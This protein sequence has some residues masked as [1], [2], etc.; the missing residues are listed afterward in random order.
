MIQKTVQHED[1]TVLRRFKTSPVLEIARKTFLHDLCNVKR[2]LITLFLMIL[3]PFFGILL[4]DKNLIPDMTT[5]TGF[6]G[7]LVFIY[8]YGLVFPIIII[9]SGTPL[10]SDELNNGTMLTLISKPIRREGI[11]LGKF[12]ALFAYG[13]LLSFVSMYIVSLTGFVRYQF[14]DSL[15]FFWIHFSYSFIVLI[16]FGGISIGISAFFNRPRN[17]MMIPL[18]IVIFSFLIELFIK[19]TIM[20]STAIG[21]NSFYE[22]FQFYH[23]DISYH[24]ANVYL[25]MVNQA[26]PSASDEWGLFLLM[27][28]VYKIVHPYVCNFWG[29][30]QVPRP[31]YSGFYPPILSG[32]LMVLLGIIILLVGLFYLKKRDIYSN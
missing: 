17:A 14:F 32:V 8:T 13:T 30:A 10:I 22:D 11:Y 18:I 6:L 5:L 7:L 31:V 29:C 24:M 27:F 2:L 12:I 4:V 16:L 1:L 28:G 23:F 25:W 26:V 9:M 21:E 15:A 3:V 19:Q 20:W